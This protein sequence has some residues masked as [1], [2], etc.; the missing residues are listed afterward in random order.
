MRKLVLDI[1]D[2]NFTP[3]F[4]GAS[5]LA[6]GTWVRLCMYCATHMTGGAIEGCKAWDTFKWG[7]ACGLD[8]AAIT[9]ATE[10]H[11]AEWRGTDLEVIGYPADQERVY[12]SRTKGA[13]KSRS[14]RLRK[15]LSDKMNSDIR[16][17]ISSETDSLPILF[18]S[19]RESA[20]RE[21]GPSD[22]ELDICRVQPSQASPKPPHPVPRTFLDFRQGRGRLF[23][24][25]E[26]AEWEHTFRLYEWDA[27]VAMYEAMKDRERIF[28][29]DALRWLE[30][31]YDLTE[32]DHA[33]A[34]AN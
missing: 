12:R 3:D 2:L 14:L 26:K 17:D 33:R 18:S 6:F 10:A 7:R 22:D 29:S 20:E 19:Q 13:S 1:Q 32:A 24:G 5:P 25:R 31:H 34:Q 30:D 23:M 15:S 8:W 28:Y 21:I 11:L 4:L 16:T 27:F 9:A